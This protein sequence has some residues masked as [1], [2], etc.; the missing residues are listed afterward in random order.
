MSKEQILNQLIERY[1]QLRSVIPAIDE[2]AGIII[3][4]YD[5]GGKL[6]VCGNGGSSSDAEH[7][8]GELMK[9]FEVKRP[10]KHEIASRLAE[11]SAERGKYLSGK[12]EAGLPA[13]SLTSQTS[14]TTAI[15]NDI[16]PS[17][18]F[19]QQIVGYGSEKDVLVAISTS[20]NS[21]NVVDACITARAMNMKVIGLTGN[22]GGKMKP[23]CDILL[24]VPENRIAYIQDLHLY[25]V[26]PE[27]FQDM[28]R[29]NRSVK[30]PRGNFTLVIRQFGPVISNL[31]ILVVLTEN[32]YII[33]HR[34]RFNDLCFQKRT[35][36]EKRCGTN[37][38]RQNLSTLP[39][40]GNGSISV[41]TT[42]TLLL[43]LGRTV[44][45]L[46]LQ[47]WHTEQ[48]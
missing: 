28:I 38:I 6:L 31:V 7:I 37:T 45:V 25:V 20:G 40:H 39:V 35:F 10:V 13:I 11:V 4:C 14:L 9:S 47:C 34:L 48:I 22:T 17:L 44:P 2:S 19:A 33:I 18:I 27:P 3:R 32:I 24:N 36:Q 46:K 42:I 5:S 41:S 30:K 29:R 15:C 23:F 12:L 21:Q 1:P 8:V 26:R 16:D 43:S